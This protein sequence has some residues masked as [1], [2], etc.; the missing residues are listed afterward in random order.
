MSNDNTPVKIPVTCSRTEKTRDV[1]LPLDQVGDF[2]ARQAAKRKNAV[3]I[4]EFINNIPVEE[5]PDMIAIY[6]GQGGVLAHVDM[7]SDSI[8]GRAFNEALDDDMFALP[9]AKARKPRTPKTPP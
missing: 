2:L 8:V 4:Q 5:R 9:E 6:K 3:L 1:H 7:K